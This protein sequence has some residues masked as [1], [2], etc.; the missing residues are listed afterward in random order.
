VSGLRWSEGEERE[1]A[2]TGVLFILQ[3]L[4]PIRDEIGHSWPAIEVVYKEGSSLT[5]LGF[6]MEHS[7]SGSMNNARIASIHRST[8]IVCRERMEKTA[9]EIPAG[10]TSSQKWYARA[11]CTDL[12]A[13]PNSPF[14]Y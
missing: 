4:L 1:G 2:K 12:P 9:Q 13:L 7:F 6:L 10:M 3:G 11:W 8:E 14:R 5:A